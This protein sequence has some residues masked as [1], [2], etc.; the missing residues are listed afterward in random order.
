MSAPNLHAFLT[1]LHNEL[2]RHPDADTYR[3]ST[4]DMKTHTFTFDSAD[5]K[6]GIQ[7]YIDIATNDPTFYISPVDTK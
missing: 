6:E 7:Q 2:Q 4:G 3:K 5:I 1:K